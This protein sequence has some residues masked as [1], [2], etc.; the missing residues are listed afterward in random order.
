[1]G[2]HRV[3][4]QRMHHTSVPHLEQIYLPQTPPENATRTLKALVLFSVLASLLMAF[5]IPTM[6]ARMTISPA[7]LTANEI[8]DIR[9]LWMD[10]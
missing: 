7:E 4:G 8:F 6:I 5:R 9:F 3:L 1:M 10:S 2:V